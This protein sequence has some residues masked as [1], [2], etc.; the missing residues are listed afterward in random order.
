[1]GEFIEMAKLWP[2]SWRMEELLFSNP[3]EQLHGH[4]TG[5]TRLRKEPVTE[6]LTLVECFAFMAALVSSRYP[7]KAPHLFAYSQTIVKASQTF[8]RPAWVAYDYQF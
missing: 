1:M 5:T 8:N 2:D 3:G 4:C 6:I 7:E